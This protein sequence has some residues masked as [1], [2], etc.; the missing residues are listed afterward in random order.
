MT[1]QKIEYRLKIKE[2]P[3]EE[4]PRERLM[5]KGAEY[6]SNSELIA[7]LLSTGTKSKS[8]IQLAEEMLV[9][10][11]GLS[12]LA[13]ASLEELSA[14]D[15]VG[16]AKACKLKAALELGKR[17]NLGSGVF[18]KVIR[19]PEDVASMLMAELR[20]LD[21]EH[22][23]AIFLDTK[24][25]VLSIE[26]ISIGTLSSSLVHPRELF[27]AGIKRS[28]AAVILIHNH[29]S[30][31]PH[32]SSEDVL[33]TKRLR[34]AG[35]LLGIEVLDHLIFGDGHYISMLEKGFFQK[36]GENII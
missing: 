30:G 19:S 20:L 9:S 3:E 33:I 1:A 15:G 4:R 21:R 2:M 7:L 8:A 32:P 24:R 35:E 23:R 22:F 11:G 16:P 29:P 12:G 36:I 6:L 28:A 31:D 18:R 17:F 34:Q 10:F 25:Q 5:E 27:K 13:A 14:I 26:T